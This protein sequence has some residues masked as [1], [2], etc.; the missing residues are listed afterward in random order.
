MLDLLRR[1]TLIQDAGGSLVHFERHVLD[2]LHQGDFSCALARAAKRRDRPCIFQRVAAGHFPDAVGDEKRGAFA[3]ADARG[4]SRIG[5][6]ADALKHVEQLKC[7]RPSGL[8][9]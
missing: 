4:R 9:V 5:R 8:S 6:D 7:D 3:D 2:A 1:D